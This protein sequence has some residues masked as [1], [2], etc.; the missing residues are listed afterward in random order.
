MAVTYGFFDS[1]NGDR[2]YNADQ[3]SEYFRGI[4]SGG[5]FQHLDGGLQVTAGTGLSVN[6]AAGRAI[7]QNRWIQNSASLPLSISAA[8]E[9]Y[10]RKDAVV[11]RLDSS[12]RTVSIT[13]KTGTPAAS[14][15]APS[16]TRS[17]GVYEMALA[18]VNVAAGATS[19]TVTDKRSD[20]AVCGWAAVA[21]ATS[22]EVDQMLND[23][24]TGFDGVVY[25]S[26]AAM[27]QGCDTKLQGEIDEKQA[28]FDECFSYITQYLDA[29]QKESGKYY[30]KNNT[31][32]GSISGM[33]VFPPFDVKAGMSYRLINVRS[34]FCTYVVGST[35]ASIDPTDDGGANKTLTFTPETDGQ[36]YVTGGDSATVMVF[37]HNYEQAEYILG[38]FDYKLKDSASPDSIANLQ[39]DFDAMVYKHVSILDGLPTISGKYYY[40]NSTSMAS[41]ETTYCYAAIPI[42]AG[43]TYYYVDLYAYFCNIKYDGESPVAFSDN[44]FDAVS[45]SFTAEHDGVVYISVHSAHSQTP[46]FTTSREMYL[47]RWPSPSFTKKNLMINVPNVYV[48]DKNG[49]GT[50]TK[51]IDAVAEATQHENSVVY[52]NAGTY[53]LVEEYGQSYLDS[54]TTEVGMILENG[55]HLICSPK[56]LITFHYTGENDQV[57]HEF[58][59]FN[60]G[61]KGFTLEGANI[62]AS[63]IRYIVHDERSNATDMYNN[64]YINCY[65]FKDDSENV[66]FPSP[67]CIGGGLGV[68]RNITVDSCHFKTVATS[69]GT[70]SLSWHN[71]PASGAK[72]KIIV[73]D[74]YF[75]GA[76][77]GCRFSWYGPSTEITNIY[78]SGCSFGK[79]IIVRGETS[80]ST[81]EN[82][83]VI[84]WNNEIRS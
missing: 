7:V 74:C 15:A 78:V 41:A 63:N 13:V 76:T 62:E 67:S 1:R 77:N 56:S 71:S 70:E 65:M 21:Q 23:M 24:K 8:S 57:L 82:I 20:S 26:P 3:M 72:S 81:I 6:V 2:K 11:L 68:N 75:E 61:P 9:T 51:L 44:S 83:N 38:S 45:G 30:Y 5:V 79:D 54:V 40:H 53:D 69:W 27:V 10:G 52:V 14:P 22:G 80:G 66:G 47:N 58:S 36:L 60:S 55:I 35:K 73:K 50:H 33:C 18:Y 39:N 12:A 32:K 19:V 4:V 64:K 31:S 34:V 43:T 49:Q 29:T 46:A 84:D 42:T 25:D 28:D 59:V 16:M 48:V 37:N 17:G